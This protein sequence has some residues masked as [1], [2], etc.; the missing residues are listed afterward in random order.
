MQNA[1]LIIEDTVVNLTNDNIN[2]FL[3]QLQQMASSLYMDLSE[4]IQQLLAAM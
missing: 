2:D 3:D 1:K 4:L